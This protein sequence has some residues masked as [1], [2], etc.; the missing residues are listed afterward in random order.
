MHKRIRQFGLS[1]LLT[2]SFAAAQEESGAVPSELMVEPEALTL[3]IGE[4]A[5][6]EATV[7]DAD[8]N[9]LDV[10]VL[11]LPLYGQ[12]WNLEERT[13]GF[14]IF[15]VRPDGTVSASRP[16][17]FKIMI[18]VPKDPN[19]GPRDTESEAFLQQE[20]PLTVLEPPVASIVFA[21]PPPRFYQ[22]TAAELETRVTDELGEL[23]DD[24][25]LVFES[26]APDVVRVD[27]D[28]YAHFSGAGRATVTARADGKQAT[29]SVNVVENP[30]ASLRLEPS[31]IEARTGDVIHLTAKL[32]DASGSPLEGVPVVYS[33]HAHTD[34]LAPGGPSS[35]GSSGIFRFRGN[36]GTP[37]RSSEWCWVQGVAS[38]GT[39]IPEGTVS[40][41]PPFRGS[42]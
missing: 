9:V 39:A 33:F 34:E 10:R 29:L 4:S 15:K 41:F 6:L 30:T 21:E 40:E 11:Y 20:V 17:E 16:G 27:A 5:K 12:F 38:I 42:V 24:V 28:G 25:S 2:A 3:N 22:G 35:D 36:A 13:W 8:G 37:E 32:T 19:A 14:N 18:R 1:A 7:K 26:D 31:A 23:R